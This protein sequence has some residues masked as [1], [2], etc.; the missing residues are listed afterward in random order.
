MGAVDSNLLSK[1]FGGITVVF[2]GYFRQILPVIPHATCGQAV[3]AALNQSRLWKFR[4]VCLL[5]KNMRLHVG[6]SPERNKDNAEFG[7]WQISIGDKKD[8][9]ANFG[10]DHEDVKIQIPNQYIV[11]PSNDPI[12]TLFDI[13]YPDFMNNLSLLEYLRSRAILTLTNQL[14]DDINCRV[15]EKIPSEE[16]IYLSQDSIDHSIDEENDFDTLFPVEY[17]NSINMP[18][19]P[20]HELKIK[21][22]ATVM[23]MRNLNQILGLYNGTRMIVTRCKK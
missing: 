16:Y 17:L 22:G 5:R 1:L 10:D 9:K 18:Y 6:N 7:K 14:V 3:G 21:V 20:K 13:T 12:Q 8:G 23:L 4:K 11:Q 15:L 19:I 2:G